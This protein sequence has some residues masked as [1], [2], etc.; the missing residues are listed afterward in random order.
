MQISLLCLGHA[1]RCDWGWGV[2]RLGQLL[3]SGPGLLRGSPDSDS[4][5]CNLCILLLS[6]C[7][8]FQT[9]EFLLSHSKI[10]KWKASHLEKLKEKN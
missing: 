8:T 4:R 9:Q 7:H 10:G 6:P 1:V 2:D 3:S 5:P